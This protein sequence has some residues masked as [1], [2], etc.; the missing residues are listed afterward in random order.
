VP[1]DHWSVLDPRHVGVL[2]DRMRAALE[3]PRP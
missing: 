2:A 1:G 3:Q